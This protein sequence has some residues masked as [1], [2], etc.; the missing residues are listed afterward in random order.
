MGIA[1]FIYTALMVSAAAAA[2]IWIGYQFKIGEVM[3]RQFQWRRRRDSPLF[4]WGSI[5]AQTIVFLS[6]AVFAIWS[7]V[8]P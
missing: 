6:W 5:A 3:D 8:Q 4:F 2:G 1:S 7:V